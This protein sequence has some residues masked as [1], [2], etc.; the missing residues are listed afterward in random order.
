MRANVKP[1]THWIIYKGYS[2]RFGRRSSQEVDGILTTESGPLPF[3]YEP[4]TRII[5]LPDQ[6][7]RINEHGW[8]LDADN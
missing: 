3:R 5:H 1:L 7:I 6:D 2:V 4:Q 8:E